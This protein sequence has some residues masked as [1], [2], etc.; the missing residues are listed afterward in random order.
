MTRLATILAHTGMAFLT[1]S[2]LFKLADLE[3]LRS[4]LAQW[5]IIPPWLQSIL[6]VSVPSLELLISGSWFV[7]RQRRH[8]LAGLA[9]V[10]CFTLGFAVELIINPRVKSC[11]CMGSLTQDTWLESPPA[12]FVRNGALMAA[13]A[14]AAWKAGSRTRPVAPDAP[15]QPRHAHARSAFTIIE[16]LCVIVLIGLIAVLIMPT[17][18]IIRD[19]GRQAVSLSNLR[20]HAAV[21]N[22][23][24]NDYKEAW[25]Y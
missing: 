1:L 5:A 20:S 24:T 4:A 3:A 8:A 18:G 10:G 16:V 17:L 14:F 2:A 19:M 9:L 25:P 13:F 7:G 23:Y 21:F 12:V 15:V 22:A 6:T 11:G